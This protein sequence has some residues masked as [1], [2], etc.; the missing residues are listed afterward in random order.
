MNH[1]KRDVNIELIRIAAC[2]SVIALHTWKG[3]GIDEVSV[4]VKGIIR[5]FEKWGVPCF[6]IIM[7]FFLFREGKTYVCR[8]KDTFKKVFI[9]VAIAYIWYELAGKWILG[10]QT[11]KECFVY[12]SVSVRDI[13]LRFISGDTSQNASFWYLYEYIKIIIMAPL[14]GLLCKQDEV[15]TKIRRG[16]EALCLVM[17][18]FLNFSR[19]L[20]NI[21][22][23]HITV[24]NVS[25]INIYVLYVLIGYEISIFD[26]KL[27]ARIRERRIAFLGVFVG[28][29]LFVC[30][31]EFIY[32]KLGGTD[33]AFFSENSV[34]FVLSSAAMF[35]FL[36]TFD[37]INGAAGRAVSLVGSCTYGVYLI[38]WTFIK[39]VESYGL[40]WTFGAL[41]RLIK[42]L[43]TVLLIFVIS[44]V[45]VSIIKCLLIGVSYILKP[46]RKRFRNDN[47]Q[48][49]V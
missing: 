7:G 1:N 47:N 13:V 23:A 24:I 10:E 26:D 22:I 31:E 36:R 27:W 6:L 14:L 3:S 42:Y 18:V 32:I 44:L 25:P 15:T 2:I 43:L 46:A 33:A 40:P 34:V 45:L 29:N 49:T 4:V 41:P 9:P 30:F 5:S 38:H 28:G 16:Y 11:L 19:F 21:D 20:Q 39:M 17:T 37:E 48:N 8:L 12:P 35:L